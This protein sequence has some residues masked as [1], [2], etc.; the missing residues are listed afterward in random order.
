LLSFIANM[1]RLKRIHHH[2]HRGASVSLRSVG[3]RSI[4]MTSNDTK[5]KFEKGIVA[6]KKAF[7]RLGLLDVNKPSVPITLV[8]TT[9]TM[10]AESSTSIEQQPC[11]TANDGDRTILDQEVKLQNRMKAFTTESNSYKGQLQK[12]YP[13]DNNN[14]IV[15]LEQQNHYH[16][17]Q[18]GEEEEADDVMHHVDQ[19]SQQ[20]Q[21]QLQSYD[22]SE[23]NVLESLIGSLSTKNTALVQQIQ[24][25]KG[26][27]SKKEMNAFLDAVY[28]NN[29]D[30]VE[31]PTVEEEVDDDGAEEVR[32]K[33]WFQSYR[34]SSHGSSNVN[35]ANVL[36]VGLS[37][38]SSSLVVSTK[39]RFQL[40]LLPS[41]SSL[42][43]LLLHQLSFSSTSFHHYP[44]PPLSTNN[45]NHQHVPKDDDDDD[46]HDHHVIHDHNNLTHDNNI[47]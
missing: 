7:E 44:H 34:S 40:L 6:K 2:H 39:T 5:R 13:I 32:S 14:A 18:E 23:D 25:Q 47:V 11:E 29:N 24:S 38:Q 22:E 10:V 21:Q 3:D 17:Q 15:D 27:I 9:T 20:H 41:S 31:V 37:R 35:G 45:N 36:T 1:D 12:V 43:N 42:S 4:S 16:Q 33:A 8:T 28:Q 26:C 30:D 46:D 19:H